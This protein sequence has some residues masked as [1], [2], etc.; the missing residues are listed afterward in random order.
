VETWTFSVSTI[1]GGL[2]GFLALY[3]LCLQFAL[4]LAWLS[5]ADLG[6]I[7][8]IA[9]ARNAFEI[10][11]TTV[12]FVSTILTAFWSYD[13]AELNLGLDIKYKKVRESIQEKKFYW[14]A[15]TK[16]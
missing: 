5:F 11:F 6:A 9:K 8:D 1:L 2:L 14:G 7:N 13:V 4:S 3:Q 16:A 12:Q 10:A 15:N